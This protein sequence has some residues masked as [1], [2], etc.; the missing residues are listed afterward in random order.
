M[1]LSGRTFYFG[2]GLRAVLAEGSIRGFGPR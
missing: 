2:P 1:W